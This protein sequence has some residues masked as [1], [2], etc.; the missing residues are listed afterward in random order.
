MKY[1]TIK[2]F[3]FTKKE[4]DYIEENANFNDNQKK[5]FAR[6]TDKNGRQSITRISIEEN[7]S[8]ATVSRL[9]KQIKGKIIRIVI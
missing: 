2:K 1:E 4:I 9:I 7:I 8:T 6:L 3:D 5:I